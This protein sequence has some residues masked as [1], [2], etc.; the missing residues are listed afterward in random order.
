[1]FHFHNGIGFGVVVGSAIFNLLF[2]IGMLG[3]VS[4]TPIEVESAVVLREAMFCGGLT[5]WFW[6]G[7]SDG[8]IAWYES[9]TL[10]TWYVLYLMIIDRRRNDVPRAN[11]MALRQTVAEHEARVHEVTT[12]AEIAC[13]NENET[14][15]QSP[16][17]SSATASATQDSHQRQLQNAEEAVIV[18]VEST[19]SGKKSKKRRNKQSQEKEPILA[20]RRPA[21]IVRFAQYLYVLF[22]AVYTLLMLPWQLVFRWTI[23]DCSSAKF[24]N[25]YLV[26]L[27]LSLLWILGLCWV[28]GDRTSLLGCNFGQFCKIWMFL[29]VHIVLD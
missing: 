21:V 24:Q 15:I 22:G 23:P 11:R 17:P 10:L 16:H 25:W 5:V 27:F 6:F 14:S 3:I 7:M 13:G 20:K 1:V 26:T 19:K 29:C 4:D 18:K 28:V 2:T 12:D 9:V 8:K